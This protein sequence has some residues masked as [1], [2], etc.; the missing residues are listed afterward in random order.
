[1]KRDIHKLT[2][3]AVFLALAL[4][5]PFLTGQIPQIGSM[6]SPMHL[7]VMLC[8]FVCGGPWGLVVG[9]VAPLLRGLLFGMPPLFPTATAMAFEL[10]AYGLFCGLFRRLFEGKMANLGN[11]YA[12]LILAM[13]CGRLVWG[14]AQFVLLGATG[15]SFT[16]QAFL[17]GAFINAVPALVLQLILVPSLVVVLEKAVPVKAKA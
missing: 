2:Y 10:A 15:G 14:A 8:G 13:L 3:S 11:L 16:F 7:P 9:F 5:L 17:A 12:S 6:L 1:M 4:V